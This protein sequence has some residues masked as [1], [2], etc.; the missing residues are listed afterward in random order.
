MSDKG[1]AIG[2]PLSLLFFCVI[3]SRRYFISTGFFVLIVSKGFR[4]I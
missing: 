2:F 4:K 1:D 3:F